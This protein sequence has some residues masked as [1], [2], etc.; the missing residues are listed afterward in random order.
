MKRNSDNKEY[1][2]DDETPIYNI[3]NLEDNQIDDGGSD[4]MDSEDES[5][6]ES[7]DKE[8]KRLSPFS[9][10]VKT[11]LTPVE[12]WKA[13]KRAAYNPDE[14]ASRCFYPL[15]T[16]AAISVAIDFYYLSDYTFTRWVEN[17][18]ST[19]VTFFFGYFTIIFLGSEI[20]PKKSKWFLKENIGKELVMLNLST[21]AIFWIIIQLL[22]ML[23]PVLVFLPIWTIYLIF[24]GIKVLRVSPEEENSTT[25]ILIILIIG[26]P[27]F[28]NW[29][30]S[31]FLL[32]GS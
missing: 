25:I 10:L 4:N 7:D 14:F 32:P 13:L 17:G 30:F 27:L 28:W 5:D 8:S 22:P 3:E 15:I 18:L 20:L 9:I 2:I 19:F 16:L 21:L 6:E 23:E 1:N 12:G 24:K 11:M 26:A 31:D 29:I